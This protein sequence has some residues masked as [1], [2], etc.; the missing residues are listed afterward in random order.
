MEI[1]TWRLED[2]KPYANN[3][4]I[5]DK[6]VDA[7]AMSIRQFGFK[8]PIIVDSGGVVIAGHTRMKAAEKLGMEEVPV[9]VADDLTEAQADAFRLVDNKTAEIAE[10]DDEKLNAELKK[11]DAELGAEIEKLLESKDED[12]EEMRKI[13]EEIRMEDYGFEMP[14]EEPEQRQLVEDSDDL[15]EPPKIPKSRLGDIYRLGVHRLICGDSTMKE[16]LSTLM[17]GEEADMVFTDPP[18]GMK[19]ENEGIANDNLNYDDLLDFNKRW[20]PLTFEALKDNGSWYC[21]GMDEPLMDIYSNILRPMKKQHGQEKLTFRNLITWDKAVG[22]GQMAP[23]Y[24]MYPIADEKCLF[25]MMGRQTYGETAADYW[26]GFEPIRQKLL[27]IK[28]GLGMSTDEIIKYAGATTCSHW[29]AVSQW[30]FP[31]EERFVALLD[32]LINDERISREEYDRIREE[33]YKTRAYF[34]NTHDNQNNVWHF[35]RTSVEERKETGGHATPKPIAL[36]GR[37]IMSSSREGEIVLDVFGGSGSTLIACEQ[38][39]RKCFMCELDPG[40]VDV[41]VTRWEKLTGKKAELIRPA[42]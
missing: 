36:C 39:K 3:P 25:V 23:D 11:I 30:E 28:N 17:D 32:N 14:V 33:W 31:N 27:E 7:V 13:L 22:Q 8:N 5:N 16:T 26:D 6:A 29:F 34:D 20:I 42:E 40:Y 12:D 24:R 21:W 41:I 19:K 10:W 15:P 1:Q 38:L 4:R 35:P 2:L 18:Y 9:I 37:A